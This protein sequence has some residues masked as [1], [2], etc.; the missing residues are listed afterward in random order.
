M[1]V[2]PHL[3]YGDSGAGDSIP[4]WSTNMAESVHGLE[5][6]IFSPDLWNS[7]DAD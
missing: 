6:L 7:N 3:A 1:V 5:S 2:P 4:G